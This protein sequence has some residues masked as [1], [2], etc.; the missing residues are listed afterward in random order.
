MLLSGSIDTIVIKDYPFSTFYRLTWL[1]SNGQVLKNKSYNY[2][3]YNFPPNLNESFSLMP[4][5]F[6]IGQ[7]NSIFAAIEIDKAMFVVK[8]DS[9][10]CDS[11]SNYCLTIGLNEYLNSKNN[12]SFFPNPAS[13]EL[14]IEFN[15][16]ADFT[17]PKQVNIIDVLGREVKTV[18][19]ETKKQKIN[20]QELNNGVYYLQLQSNNG[21]KITKKLVKE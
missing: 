4:R 16:K 8:F 10:G 2:S 20:L 3:P 17:K 9:T 15:N 19:I 1:D 11:S 14:T 18:F 6:S 7:N 12:F 5:N 21:I 13:N